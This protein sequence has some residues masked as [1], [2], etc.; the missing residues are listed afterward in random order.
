MRYTY[1]VQMLDDDGERWHVLG[2]MRDVPRDF[3][4][5]FVFGWRDKRD[6]MRAMRIVRSD[7][8]IVRDEP[9]RTEVPLGMVAGWPSAQTYRDAAARAIE[10]AEQ[11][12]EYE[13]QCA[14]QDAETIARHHEMI[15][16]D[17]EETS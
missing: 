15:A 7:G 4:E 12:E 8:K 5:G 2:G 14:K 10:K 16:R 13:R 6:L 1:Q 11:I 17:S 3:A 9:A